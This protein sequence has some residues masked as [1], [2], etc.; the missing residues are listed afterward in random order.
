ML[1]LRYAIAGGENGSNVALRIVVESGGCHRRPF[2]VSNGF[3]MGDALVELTRVFVAR[4]GP[5]AEECDLRFRFPFLLPSR[6]KY[7]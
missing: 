4:Q 2:G 1:L 6:L 7:R 3:D 5:R